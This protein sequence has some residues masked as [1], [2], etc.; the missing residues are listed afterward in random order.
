M[1][2]H[3]NQYCTMSIVHFVA[4]PRRWERRRHRESVA[5]DRQDPFFGAGRNHH[6][7][8]MRRRKGGRQD[9]LK[10]SHIRWA[11]GASQWC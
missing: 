9:V 10:T 11:I 5:V 6:G 7:Q 8:G 4:F 2:K 3:W 1:T